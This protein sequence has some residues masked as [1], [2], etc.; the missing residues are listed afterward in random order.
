ML[1][2][3]TNL[4]SKNSYVQLNKS[5]IQTN[6]NGQLKPD[7]FDCSNPT[8]NQRNQ[9]IPAKKSS[10][11][12]FINLLS[13]KIIISKEVK[14]QR[15][16]ELTNAGIEPDYI[17]SFA[18]LNETQY[19]RAL[20]LANAGVK[21]GYIKTLSELEELQFK[22][23]VALANAGVNSLYIEELSNFDATQ[24][25]NIL[26]LSKAGVDV[27][28]IKYILNSSDSK[29]KKGIK[30]AQSGLKSHYILECLDLDKTKFERALKLAQTGIKS[31]YISKLVNLENIQFD[32]I[33]KLK[34][35]GIKDDYILRFAE[36]DANEVINL[37]KKG[38]I[39]HHIKDLI[40]LKKI[41]GKKVLDAIDN[42]NSLKAKA[43]EHPELY[44]NGEFENDE[45]AIKIVNSFFKSRYYMLLIKLSDCIDKETMNNLLRMRFD[46]AGR[47]LNIIDNFNDKDSKLLK[48]LCS[49]SSV[50][51]KPINSTQKI[52]FIDLISGYKTNNLDTKKIQSMIKT[53]NIDITE[54]NM[55]LFK[56]I[57]KTLG[58]NDKDL[59][60]IPAEKLNSWNLTYMPLLS[61]E[62]VDSCTDTSDFRNILIASNLKDFKKFIQDTSNIYGKINSF[63]KSLFKNE[64]MN[65]EAWLTPSKSNE[66]QFV[67]KDKNKEQ[68]SQI[69]DKITYD[70]EVLR[71][72]PAKD[73][74]NKQLSKYIKDDEFS[75]P[76]ECKTSKAKLTEFTENV[77]KQFE[78]IFK[79]AQ[80]NLNNPEKALTAKNTLTIQNHLKQSL[81]DIEQVPDEKSNKAINITIKMWDR[82]PQKDLF[83]GNYSTCCIGMGEINGSAMPHYLL[84]TAYNMIELTDNTTGKTI[85]NALCYFSKNSK[86]NPIFIIDNIEIKNSEIP[87]DTAGLELRNSI[88]QY[89]SNVAKEVTGKNDIKI[90]MGGAYNDIP[91]S[92]LTK[93]IEK[94]SFLGDVANDSVYM[95]LY[96]G[97]VE[98]DYLTQLCKLF[99]L[100]P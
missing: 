85:G 21:S 4:I 92:D 11:K 31:L 69:A 44:V 20:K 38:V 95:D 59:N 6:F 42:V 78:S 36:E 61:K 52:A 86:K 25:E 84:N 72:T 77:Q 87:S 88:A 43:L 1:I 19:Q 41:H 17:K 64:N 83:Q 80:N 16:T 71:Q 26:K 53:G 5:Y 45:D 65:Y 14:L 79:R 82:I 22:K 9:T 55:D 18:K 76:E 100:K 58:F 93:K 49:S 39:E 97:W 13:E 2:Q 70:I 32:N 81:S 63:T 10:L 62:I 50:N 23:A 35:A 73:F 33:L 68:L 89:A 12:N 66:I 15:K 29:I 7:C 47:Y 67:V 60:R 56:S 91:T 99:E 3:K 24:F 90:Y 57:L 94:I 28:V 75:I 8:N 40:T 96:G 54:L 46:D 34:S 74:I 48:D 37:F 98:R 51:N 27:D 30:L